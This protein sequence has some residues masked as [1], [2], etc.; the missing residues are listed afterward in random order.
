MLH[1]S[2][3]NYRNFKDDVNIILRL[4]HSTCR[5]LVDLGNADSVTNCPMRDS[6][7]VC[8]SLHQSVTPCDLMW[9]LRFMTAQEGQ[10]LFPGPVLANVF[11]HRK[12]VRLVVGC[13][14][15]AFI[16]RPR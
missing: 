5:L 13:F 3:R 9:T 10:I 14:D 7:S 1:F 15:F 12:H 4:P 16:D 6:A 11:P 2:I 8:I